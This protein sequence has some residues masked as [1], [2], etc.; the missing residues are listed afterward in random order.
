M[1][2]KAFFML[3]LG[4]LVVG[5]VIGG[6]FAGG[7][8]LGRNQAGSKEETSATPTL[9]FEQL[10]QQ[11]QGQRGTPAP[12][13]FAAG[14]GRNTMAGTIEKIEG[15]TMT[16]NTQQGPLT[17]KLT[18]DV[19][20]QKTTQTTIKDLSAGMQVTVMG[21]RDESG[22]LQASTIVVGTTGQALPFSPGGTPGFQRGTPGFQRG[23]PS[24]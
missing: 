6:A 19:P 24:P 17:V 23:T 13:D 10:R 2:T 1:S 8:V 11:F 18:A 15:D 4:V 7:I 21:Q 3:L 12:G 16:V 20:V 5:G 22:T 14:L 9:D